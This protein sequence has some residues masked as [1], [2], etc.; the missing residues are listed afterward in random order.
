MACT[1]PLAEFEFAHLDHDGPTSNLELRLQRG[2]WIGHYE[3]NEGV[4]AMY[5][6]LLQ[7]Y[8]LGARC[9]KCRGRD[10]MSEDE[11]VEE[12]KKRLRKDRSYLDRFALVPTASWGKYEYLKKV[13]QDEQEATRLLFD[14]VGPCS[15]EYEWLLT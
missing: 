3:K 7:K 8:P 11:W 10:R 1:T 15:T 12:L 9:D 6:W 5:G 2:E 13:V 4:Q 14:P